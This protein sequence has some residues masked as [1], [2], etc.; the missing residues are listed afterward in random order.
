LTP[1]AARRFA[2]GVIVAL[3]AFG[4]EA[5]D[6]PRRPPTAPVPAPTA[7]RP[8]FAQVLKDTLSGRQFEQKSGESEPA[9]RSLFDRLARGE[10]MLPTLAPL[11][12]IGRLDRAVLG[13][14]PKIK[15][16][17]QVIKDSTPFLMTG[18]FQPRST[19]VTTGNIEHVQLELAAGR[20]L[21]YVVTLRGAKAAPAPIVEARAVETQQCRAA[22]DALS[23]QTGTTTDVTITGQGLAVIRGQPV[24]VIAVRTKSNQHGITL[25]PL[26]RRIKGYQVGD[27]WKFIAR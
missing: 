13:A 5:R 22:G 16:P 18:E 17:S 1:H 19:G 21:I 24:W 10:Y 14:C 4:A 20:F 8:D 9:S 27:G 6:E 25:Q 7:G 11:P 23:L 12:D 15:P 26:D 3:L 2:G